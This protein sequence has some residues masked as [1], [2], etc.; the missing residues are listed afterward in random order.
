MLQYKSY[1]HLAI[2]LAAAALPACRTGQQPACAPQCCL[3]P[4]VTSAAAPLPAPTMLASHSD[5]DSLWIHTDAR[6]TA[7]PGAPVPGDG[8]WEQ[9]AALTLTD[10]IDLTIASNPDLVSASE[11]IFIA[12]AALNRARS[13]FYPRLGIAQQYGVS[14][15]PAQTF[16]Y[17]L[18]QRQ[19]DP[20]TPLNQQNTRDNFLTQLSLEHNL[21]S[22]DRRRHQLSAEAARREA[23]VSNLAAVQNQ[24]VFDA[25]EAYYRLL[26]A[27][28]LV[29]VREEAV[30]QVEQHLKIVQSR[31]RN[32]TAVKSDVLT[33][34][35]RLAEVREAEITAKNQLELAWSVLENVVGSPIGRA[36]LPE[37]VLAAPWSEYADEL[38]IAIGEAMQL[39]PELGVVASQRRAAAEGI[40]V[41]RS[42]KRVQA[43]AVATYNVFTRDFQV[44]SE[45][46]FL[47][48][49]ASLNL[50]D[51]GRT[52]YDV[53][54]AVARLREL[55]AR[56]QRLMLDI[57]LDVRRSHLQLVDARQRLQVA[58]QA[59]GQAGES[60]REI[61]VRYR[62]QAATITELIDAQ[63]ALSNARVRR[64]NA[65][66]DVEIARA[67]LQRAIGRLS[68]VL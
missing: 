8:P 31:Y 33:V 65:E 55:R 25:A 60:L 64:A 68:T 56:E 14:D 48:L 58:T 45:A 27:N 13:E 36:P 39:R 37:D 2:L 24:L 52:D 1:A 42:G 26:Q 12:E 16:M 3:P 59:I 63:V 6:A 4:P 22:G 10:V 35:V 61:E 40:E 7:Q 57:E 32:E 51:G 50:F 66:A 20:T 53:E 54:Q 15:I 44:G 17:R 67:S 30:R 28:V 41:A 19:L 11:Q 18:N 9:V 43:D 34:E 62:G 46:Y 49:I 38:E 5:G 47:G 21:Y 23:A 29:G